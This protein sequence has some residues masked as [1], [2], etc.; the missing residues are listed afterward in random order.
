MN[1]LVLRN[2]MRRISV[3]FIGMCILLLTASIVRAGTV[4]LPGGWRVDMQYCRNGYTASSIVAGSATASNAT[5]NIVINSISPIPTGQGIIA[6]FS[7]NILTNGPG[8]FYWSLPQSPGAPVTASISRVENGVLVGTVTDAGTIQDCNVS[9]QSPAPL[10]V[11]D[12]RINPDPIAPVAI[13]CRPNGIEILSIDG[14]GNG[15]FALLATQ[16]QINAVGIPARN[17]LIAA[18]GG[19]GLFRLT[20]GEFQVNVPTFITSGT[21]ASTQPQ[22]QTAVTTTTTTTSTG[23]VIHVVQRGEN[24]FRISL[25]YGR[26]MSAIAAANGITNFN[27]IYAGQRL[28][29]PAGGSTPVTITTTTGIQ[30]TAVAPAAGTQNFVAGEDYVFAW[31]GC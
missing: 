19:V 13:Y 18:G 14:Q 3:I 5:N 10:A 12:N 21:T 8:I 30:P 2:I 15:H 29:I 22:Q 1:Q 11:P 16:N 6:I 24:L 25:R 28:I 26:T 4:N 27:L 23:S 17:A 20:S 31:G 7:G 9:A